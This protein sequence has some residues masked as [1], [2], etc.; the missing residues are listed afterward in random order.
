MLSPHG[1]VNNTVY[2]SDYTTSNGAKIIE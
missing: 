1:L 2:T